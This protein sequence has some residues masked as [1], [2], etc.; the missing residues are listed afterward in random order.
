MDKQNNN[1]KKWTNKKR[2]KE[3]NNDKKWKAKV[4]YELKSKK[5]IMIK[6]YAIIIFIIFRDFLTE[7]ICLSLQVKPSVIITN[8]V[9]VYTSDI[10]SCQT[11]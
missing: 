7:Q 1:E 8:K 3:K 5:N 11:T 6:L 2:R 10:T 9:L 4:W